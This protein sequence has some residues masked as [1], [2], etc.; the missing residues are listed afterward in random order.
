MTARAAL[1]LLGVFALTGCGELRREC[2]AVVKRA[3]AFLA[4]SASHRPA[5][6]APPERAAEEARSTAARYEK[7]AADLAALDVK[8]GDL[9]PEVERYRELAQRSAASL[10]AAAH[11]L[12]TKHFEQARS[13]RVALDRASKSEAPLVA[14]INEICK[15]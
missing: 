15:D 14:R 1:A 2:D 7:L 8:S 13:E 3:N 9:K 6:G 12:E 5:P 10:K 4:E 11:A